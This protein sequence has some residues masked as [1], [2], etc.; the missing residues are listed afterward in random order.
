[1]YEALRTTPFS[2]GDLCLVQGI[3]GLGHL[4]IQYAV[5]LGLKVYAVSSGPTKAALAMSLGA[6]G[7]IDASAHGPSVIERV[8]A[9]GGAKVILCTTPSA[10]QTS[11][12]IPAVARDGVVTLVGVAMDGDVRI[13]NGLMV[14][15]RATLRGWGCGTAR[16]TESCVQ[17]SML[18]GKHFICGLF[19]GE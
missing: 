3:G 6:H 11:A 14:M 10:E 12:L 19:V 5:R 7:Y 18:T 15:R 17:F 16:E 2:P 4:A 8:Q 1:M 9:M 13:N